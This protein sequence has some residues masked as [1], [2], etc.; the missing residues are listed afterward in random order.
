MNLFSAITKARLKDYIIDNKD[1]C[2]FVVQPDE[3]GKS[4]GKKGANVR[5]LEKKLNRKIKIVEFNSEVKQFIRNLV[6]PLRLGDV[7][8]SDDVVTLQAEDSKTRGLLIGRAASNLRNF[9]AITKRYFDIKE[10]K[11]V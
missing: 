5:L 8:V 10:I 6:Y 1:T 9:E 11:V 7:D 3:L 4:I 2:V